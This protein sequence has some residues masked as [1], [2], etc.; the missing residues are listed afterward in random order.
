M[1]LRPSRQ[2]SIA[3][4]LLHLGALACLAPLAFSV[5]LKVP[6]VLAVVASL[7]V[8]LRRSALLLAG[9]SVVALDP[10]DDG[11]LRYVL[12]NGD[13][14]E[15]DVLA[16][17][18]VYPFAA[19]I[20]MRDRDQRRTRS[21]LVLSDAIDAESFRRLRVWLRWRSAVSRDAA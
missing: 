15:A 16:D 3:L 20:W 7:M 4:T 21:V 13:E 10:K 6:L 5:W 14:V 9:D 11:M 2:M 12:R 1:K 19:A 17:T 18:A 8:A